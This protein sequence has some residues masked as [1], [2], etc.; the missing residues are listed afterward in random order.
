[1]P[2]TKFKGTPRTKFKGFSIQY[3]GKCVWLTER[4]MELWSIVTLAENVQKL[5]KHKACNS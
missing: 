2:R 3:H 4:E 5:L 1:M